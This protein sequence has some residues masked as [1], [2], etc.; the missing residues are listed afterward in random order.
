MTKMALNTSDFLRGKVWCPATFDQ[1]MA[2]LLEEFPLPPDVPGAMVRYRQT[3]ALSLL[4]KSFLTLSHAFKLYPLP[5]SDHSAA[6][7][8]HKDP[9]QGS[10]LFDISNTGCA[11]LDP[12]RKPMKHSSA[13]KQASGEAIYVDDIPKIKGEL[14]LGFVLSTKAHAKIQLIDGSQA[15]QVPGVSAFY[16]HKD[17]EE[18]W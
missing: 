6:S 3:L 14:H 1:A 4:F 16:C 7:L 18:V 17:I 8:F 15:L 12:L 10:Q 5:S 13:D 9:L 11:D 2:L